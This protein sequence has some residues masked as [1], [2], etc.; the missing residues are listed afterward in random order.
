M[1]GVMKLLELKH[2]GCIVEPNCG[3]ILSNFMVV[4]RSELGSLSTF[5]PYGL[6]LSMGS[7]ILRVV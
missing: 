6:N 3:V 5:S 1:F 4:A 7:G 2:G